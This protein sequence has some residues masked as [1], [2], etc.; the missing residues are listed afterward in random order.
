MQILK[1]PKKLVVLLSAL[2][3]VFLFGSVDASALPFDPLS[4]GLNVGDT[5]RL[6]FVTEDVHNATSTD[7]NDYNNFVT[8]E[9][10]Q[11]GAVTAG[12]GL[13]WAA[14]ASTQT[15]DALVNT[16]T[17]PAAGGSP[18]FKVDGQII[19]VDNGDLWDGDTID[20]LAVNQFG[21]VQ[22]QLARGNPF[23]WTG[24][25]FNGHTLLSSTAFLGAPHPEFGNASSELTDWIAGGQSFPNTSALPFYAISS[26]ILVVANNNALP[27]PECL[28]L[29]GLGVA[30][31]VL[32]RYRIRDRVWRG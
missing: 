27:E 7:I 21:N 14:I 31:L 23:V 15:K 8:A 10:N 16:N 3:V 26:P 11:S 24:T 1:N 17:D 4:V 25:S 29:F 32:C 22:T 9:A 28:V 13:T 5:F 12:L 19:A 6:A 30:G 2:Y 18:I 20:P